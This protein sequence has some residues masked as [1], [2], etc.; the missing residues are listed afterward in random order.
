M[1]IPLQIALFL[2]SVAIVIFVVVCI[3]AILQLRQ[4][5]AR[6]SQ[7]LA[8]LKAEVSLLVQDGRRLLYNVNELSTR[9]HQQCDDVER[10]IQTVRGWT[11]RVDRVV[12]EVGTVLEPPIL[13][14]AR[15]A[16]IFRKGIA[17]FF[18]T[19]LNR[20]R[21]Q[22]QKTEEQHVRQ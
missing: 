15:N 1:S 11:E 22:P 16:R 17:V 21:H 5:A 20:N 8:E 2:A 10:V 13:T 9:A 7:T 14:A 6:M 12:E 19:F 3:P 18:E 4:Q